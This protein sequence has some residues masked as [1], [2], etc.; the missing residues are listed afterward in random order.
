[1]GTVS[2]IALSALG[3][4]KRGIKVY[5]PTVFGTGQE[6]MAK[7]YKES[8]TTK[9]PFKKRF[10]QDMWTGTKAAGKAAEKH[11]AV[12][13][14][15][16][17]D[18]LKSTIK[19]LKT[20]PKKIAQ[21][22]KIGGYKA[23]K[24]GKNVLLGKIGGLFKGIGTRMP[25]IG[26][27]LMIGFEIPNIVK[28]TINEGIVQG[29]AEIVKAGA[30]LGGATILGALGT[31]IGGPIGG[32]VGFIAG[33]WIMSKIVGKSYSEREMEQE[34][35]TAQMVET[36]GTAAENSQAAAGILNQNNMFTPEQ[37]MWMNNKLYNNSNLNDDFMY[38][39]FNKQQQ[40]NLQA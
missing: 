23:Q 24:A 29:G 27:L 14:A 19:G 36:T 13:Q 28:A 26:S 33:D 40:L 12:N 32:I 35:K 2:R 25:L 37:L 22:W 3:Y 7:A 9:N 8:L 39:A 5:V 6:V 31:A 30:R 10:W 21:G 20:I 4:A 1:M 18:F 38:N 15:K 11:A 16:N 17:G 34:E